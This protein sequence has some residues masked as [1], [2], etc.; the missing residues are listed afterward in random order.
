MTNIPLN[1]AT[2]VP[3]GFEVLH[4]KGRTGVSRAIVLRRTPHHEDVAIT[5]I[6]PLPEQVHFPNVREVL[7]EFLDIVKHVGVQSVQQ[8]PIGEAYVQF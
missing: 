6:H 3:L 4:V 7:E 2:F 1:P 5:T 8:C